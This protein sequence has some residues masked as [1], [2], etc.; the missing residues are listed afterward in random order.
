MGCIRDVARWSKTDG[1]NLIAAL[2]N[3]FYGKTESRY[4]LVKGIPFIEVPVFLRYTEIVTTN[5]HLTRSFRP[6][7]GYRT[8]AAP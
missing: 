8:G 5:V 1:H 6:A 4:H 7:D 3:K 2:Y